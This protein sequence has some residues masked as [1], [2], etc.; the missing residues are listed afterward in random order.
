MQMISRL[1]A[2]ALLS[3]ALAS[4]ASAQ[5]SYPMITHVTPVAVQ[6][7][8]STEITVEGQMNF[9]GVHT[10][11]IEGKGVSAEVVPGSEGKVTPKG[12]AIPVVRSVKLK[13]TVEA[14]AELGVREFRLASNLGISTLGQI[15]VV[16]DPVVME[17]AN[18]NLPATAQTL[19]APCV[20]S[21]KIEALEDVDCFKLKARAGQTITCEVYCARIE[22]KIHDLQKHADPMLTLLDSAGRELAASD[23]GIFADPLLTYTFKEDG[24]YILQIRDAKY[25][26]DP[27][28]VY[29]LAVTDRPCLA[30][31]HP[32]AFNPSQKATVEPVGSAKLVQPRIN[33]QAPS[34]A[35]IHAI[36]LP[37]GM[38]KTNPTACIVTPLPLIAE[39]EPND[40]A[41]QANRLPIPCGVNGRI[42]KRRDLDHYTFKAVKGKA[43][44][45]EVFARRFGTILTSQLDSMLD[46]LN[47][48]GAIVASNDDANGKDAALV[49]TPTT[50]GEYTLRIRDL[51]SKGGE[52]FVYYLECDWAKPDFTL[53]CDPSKAMIGPG[54]HAAWYVQV[55]RS[56]GFAG[57]V[58]IEVK[59]L[60]KEV[61]VNPLVIPA[62]MTQGLLVVSTS[63][64]AT[65]P[66][67]FPVE[68]VGTGEISWEG[69]TETLMRKSIA[70][71]EIYSPGGGR[72]R[73][74]V[75]M[76]SI[77][78]TEPTDIIDVHVKQEK[79][80]LKPGEEVKIEFEILRRKDYDKAVSADVI[81]RHLGTIFGNPLPPG[82]T[83]VEG[84]SKTLLGTGNAGHIVLKVDASAAPIEDV[85]IS[86][87][88]HVSINFVVKVS[89]SSKPILLSIR[90]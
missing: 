22:D 44:R 28:W 60:P 50:D 27:R 18:N 69:K 2:A 3:F 83:M 26:G 42:E 49:F 73:F 62:S 14:D 53:K 15:L 81:L 68:I 29:A 32:L 35:G 64:D 82:V 51:N 11:L 79:L 37:L 25:D 24:E 86:V 36:Q 72:A 45:F 38:T 76:Q 13:M 8:K 16:D 40:A 7:G 84:K 20:V 10:L 55:A 89:Y 19:Q 90:K 41:S 66:M 65:K 52:G 31:M 63:P 70:H 1:G 21:G 59:G 9:A 87:L 12:S 43:I 47:A 48:Q 5:T 54:G 77:A 75:R 71:E 80:V 58:K 88:A 74:D 33:F 4:I 23:D 57:P 34:D 61:T 39:Q 67:G 17:A 46:I 85:P 56:N 6:R 30:Q 78:I